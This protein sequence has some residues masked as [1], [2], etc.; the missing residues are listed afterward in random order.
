MKRDRPF[1]LWKVLNLWSESRSNNQSKWSLLR[2]PPLMFYVLAIRPQAPPSWVF[3]S[4]GREQRPCD[5][6]YTARLS[7]DVRSF[8][9]S[10]KPFYSHINSVCLFDFSRNQQQIDEA[11]DPPMIHLRRMSYRSL[12]S[13]NRAAFILHS[14]ITSTHAAFLWRRNF[15]TTKATNCVTFISAGIM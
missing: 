13:A 5:P 1:Y 6:H 15:S 11:N 2:P 10:P 7:T 9:L 4:S 14:R 3:L 12:L 8:V